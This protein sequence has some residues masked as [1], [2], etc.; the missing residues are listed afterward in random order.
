MIPPTFSTIQVKKSWKISSILSTFLFLLIALLSISSCQTAQKIT[1]LPTIS[2]DLVIN[3]VNVID[4]KNGL[5]TNR[6]VVIKDNK[7]IKNVSANNLPFKLNSQ[8]TIDGQGRYLLPGLWDAHVHLSFIKE[9]TPSMFPLFIAHGITSIRDTGGQLH[10]VTPERAKARKDPK[11]TPR[12]MIAGP[13]LD[14]VPTVYDGSTDTNPHLGVGAGT[15]EEGEK[16]VDKMLAADVDLL[17]VYEMLSPEVFSSM[18]ARANEAGKVVTGHVPLSMDVIE[19]SNLGLN[20]ME[21]MRNLEFACSSDWEV[22]KATRKKML[23]EGKEK[24]GSTL[25]RNIHTAQRGHAVANQDA[26]RRAAVLKVLAENETWQVPTLSI[27][28]VSAERFFLREDWQDSYKYLPNSV[29][30]TWIENS[31]K[32]GE[33]DIPEDTKAYTNWSFEMISHLK[34]ANV[35]IMAGTDCPI[36]YLTPGYSLHEELA[37]LVKGGLTPLEAIE[38]ATLKPAQ[39]FSLDKE[40]GLVQEGMLADLLLL[41]KNPLENIRNTKSIN[42]VIRDGKL[43]DRQALDKLLADLEGM[44]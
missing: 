40:L 2:S 16:L 39:Y 36:F 38:A 3:N 37:L 17:K 24:I 25:R 22:L 28:T 26:T 21:H 12:V 35:D 8:T 19:A 31:N 14:G 34:E 6:T 42:A 30:K 5:Q 43:H 44:E 27:M 4:A 11:N 20:S 18:M 23:F 1:T 13:L 9:L 10:L 33:T 7:I 41:D 29:Q 32:F 15:I